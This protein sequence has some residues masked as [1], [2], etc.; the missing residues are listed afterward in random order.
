MKRT[1]LIVILLIVI[2]GAWY[3][4]KEY[5]RKNKDLAEAKAQVTTDASALLAAFEKDSASA[6]RQYLGKI[7]AVHGKIKSIER[8]DGATVVLGETGSMSSVRCSMDTTHLTEVALIKEGQT[9]NIKGV[10]NGFNRD[11]LLGSDVILNR[12]VLQADNKK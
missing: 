3:G 2:A 9:I 6:N 7:V 5:N 1:I 4:F 12:C 10:C 8:E 11:E